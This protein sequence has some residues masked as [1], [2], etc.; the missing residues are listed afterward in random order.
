ME[1]SSS[2]QRAGADGPVPSWRGCRRLR[3][4]SRPPPGPCCRCG[5]RASMRACAMPP[6]APAGACWHCPRNGSPRARRPL[7]EA[8]SP[9]RSPPTWSC[10]PAR[11]RCAAPRACTGCACAADKRCSRWATVPGARWRGLAWTH[12][13]PS[14]WTARACSPCPPCN[15]C[16]GCASAWSPESAAA[17]A[18][19]RPCRHAAHG[20]CARMFMPAST[21]GSPAHAG[22]RL[23]GR[24]RPGSATGWR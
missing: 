14:G 18:S 19:H 11:T 23:P 2:A 5:R 20:C 9:P 15:G 24:W 10:S 21:D 8:P 3:R 12:K 6:R 1:S 22:T 4:P 17:T 13:R 16:A 7:P